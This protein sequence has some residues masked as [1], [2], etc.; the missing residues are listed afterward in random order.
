MIESRLLREK[1]GEAM[2]KFI[3]DLR[4]KAKIEI[5]EANLEKLKTL[6]VPPSNGKKGLPSLAVPN[7]GQ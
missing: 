5:F 2:D 3:E 4:K 7:M 6:Q 1:R